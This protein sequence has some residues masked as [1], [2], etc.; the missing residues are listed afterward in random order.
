[1][2]T[3][4]LVAGIALATIAYPQFGLCV[5]SNHGTPERGYEQSNQQTFGLQRTLTS[6]EIQKNKALMA[7]RDE[8]LKLR[9][10]DG[11]TLTPEHH[12]YLQAKLDAINAGDF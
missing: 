10:A 11:G 7:L 1:M 2:N 5:G 8:G 6:R 9:E 12:A 3:R 4:L